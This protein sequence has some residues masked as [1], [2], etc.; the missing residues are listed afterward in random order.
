MRGRVLPDQGGD[1]HPRGDEHQ[2]ESERPGDGVAQQPHGQG[3]E[4]QVGQGHLVTQPPQG[5]PDTSEDSIRG[6]DQ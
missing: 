5:D 6:V 3:V 1:G 4:Q 2:E